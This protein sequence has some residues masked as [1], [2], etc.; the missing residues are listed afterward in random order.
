M[1]SL[2]HV[3]EAVSGYFALLSEPMRL[4]IL[5]SICREEK[6]V[7][8]IVAEIGASQTN[9]SRHLNTLY[10]AGALNRRKDGNFT[11]YGVRDST[12]TEICRTVCTHIAARGDAL[13]EERSGMRYLAE[14]MGSPAESPDAERFADEDALTVGAERSLD[15]AGRR[16]ARR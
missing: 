12:L 1:D 5:H 4:R 9:V 16:G 2:G 6:S 15:D 10:R 14:Q 7:S 11:Y 3:F 8:Q 13:A